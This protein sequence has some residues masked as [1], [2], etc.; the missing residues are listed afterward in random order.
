LTFQKCILLPSSGCSL[1]QQDFM[2]LYSRKLSHLHIC[3]RENLKSHIAN[4]LSSL[5]VATFL[6]SKWSL[7]IV[8]QFLRG[9]ATFCSVC[10]AQ[11][12]CSWS[13]EKILSQEEIVYFSVSH[14]ERNSTVQTMWLGLTASLLLIV[15]WELLLKCHIICFH[16]YYNGLIFVSYL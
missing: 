14:I 8:T 7:H 13:P 11:N 2:T 10:I 1:L 16:F 9:A 5:T 6:A 3:H 4:H 12:W 15:T